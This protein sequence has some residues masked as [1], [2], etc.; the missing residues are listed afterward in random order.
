MDVYQVE[1]IQYLLNRAGRG[2]IADEMGLGKT[3]QSI[4][5]MMCIEEQLRRL[6]ARSQ[7]AGAASSKI[8][9]SK[10]VNLLPMKEL[11]TEKM[12]PEIATGGAG[13]KRKCSNV[14]ETV[15]KSKK[16]RVA[17]EQRAAATTVAS[18]AATVA[19]ITSHLIICPATI[20]ENWN[21][22][23]AKH[24]S[25]YDRSQVCIITSSKHLAECLSETKKEPRRKRKKPAPPSSIAGVRFWIMS[26]DLLVRDEVFTL[27]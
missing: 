27:V 25:D 19:P 18:V 2:T 12:E 22:E 10:V 6:A 9:E 23:F 8:N 4:G 7:G 26:Y 3:L 17:Q 1:G 20:R 15:P 14:S 5:L 24:L 16:Q 11:Q 13:S 21:I